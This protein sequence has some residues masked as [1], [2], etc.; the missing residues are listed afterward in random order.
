MAKKI[1]IVDDSMAELLNLR[2]LLSDAG[3]DTVTASSG[4]EGVAKAA[5][6]K[7]AM[8]LMDI[9]M[10]E[11]DGYEACRALRADPVLKTIPVVIVSSKNQKADHLWATMQGARALLPKPVQPEQLLAMVKAYA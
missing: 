1:L 6:E 10:P 7:P 11:M 3:Y 9:V 4:R 5:S 2:T 8:I